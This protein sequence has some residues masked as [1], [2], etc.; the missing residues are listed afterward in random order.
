MKL[1]LLARMLI[2]PGVALAMMVVLAGTGWW[3]MDK[4][5]QSLEHVA[6]D[7]FGRYE[8]ATHANQ[9]AGE[10]HTQVYRTMTWIA[11]YDE[12]KIAAVI[13][14]GSKHIDEILA[15]LKKAVDQDDAEARK[16]ADAIAKV[17]GEYRK[18][19]ASALEIAAGDV[20]MGMTYM[21][22][23]DGKFVE[24]GK[25]FK[26]LVDLQKAAAQRAHREAE[27]AHATA[28]AI[29]AA[30]LGLS[31]A[32]VVVVGVLMARGLIALLG[33]EP[34][35]AAEI[36]HRVSRGDMAVEVA[37]RKGDTTSLLAAMKEMVARLTG[38]IREVRGGAD[39]LTSTSGQV[40][41][42]AQSIS[43]GASEQAA[44]VEETTASIEQMMASITQN[45]ENAKVTD[46][47]ASQAAKDAAEGGQAVG[48]TVAAMKSIAGKIGIID[49]I[50]YQTNLLALNAAIE[51]ARAGQHGKG[52]AVVAAEVRKL[53]ERSQVAAQ[54]IGRLAGS[55]VETAERAGKLLETMVPS[56]G[57]TSSLVQEIAAA[58]E[59]QATGVQQVN[60]AI[61]QLNQA[62][63]Q[64]A[65]ASEEL[66]ATAEEMS[67]QAEQLQQA[68]AFFKL[69]AAAGAGAVHVR[70]AAVRGKRRESEIGTL[71]EFLDEAVAAH[72]N[73]KLRLRGFCHGTE[74]LDPAVV[75]RDDQCAMGKWIYGDG[76][77][78][79]SHPECGT[80][81]A[82]HAQFHKCAG[83]VAQAVAEGNAHAAERMLDDERSK[84]N[85]ASTSTVKAI[86]RF[87]KCMEKSGAAGGEH[88]FV[89]F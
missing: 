87:K 74:K 81:R 11:N 68:M 78:Y 28:L 40:S 17:M 61:G 43:Q 19:A 44:S 75:G 22:T 31:L 35:Y 7:Q 36:V 34:E 89:R 83:E 20:N 39:T 67:G 56:I 23:A 85:Q 18:L 59:E 6:V 25:S 82:E 3:A 77:K 12:A 84:F 51:A 33:G 30:V 80:V 24:M 27:A 38:V 65:S 9:A 55:S 52:F 37:V 15:Q 49:D 60:N 50:A 58:S 54:E 48:Q 88:G 32:L 47:M 8:A 13:K 79:E 62:T 21:Q 10:V 1:K 69:E 63:Q 70:A 16:H 66:A 64:N 45:T 76:A 86:L 73:F 41:S 72:T 57:K 46:G 29:G 5:R 2:G 14:E 71:G 4:Q 42:T 26:G 53:A